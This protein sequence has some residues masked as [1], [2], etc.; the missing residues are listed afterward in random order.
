MDLYNHLFSGVGGLSN[1][2]T[3]SEPDIFNTVTISGSNGVIGSIKEGIHNEVVMEV[4]GEKVATMK[5]GILPDQTTIITESGNLT[6]V[7]NF[8]GGI[9]LSDSTGVIAQS[10]P[11]VLGGEDWINSSTGE[12][13]A[14]TSPGMSGGMDVE[15]PVNSFNNTDIFMA[16]LDHISSGTDYLDAADAFATGSDALT[17][18][19]EFL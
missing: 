7:E 14:K 13:L 16:E 8:S 1:N 5:D 9:S 6:A 19:S 2:V 17:M 4:G 15:L 11:N 3:F 10:S 18:F 12:L